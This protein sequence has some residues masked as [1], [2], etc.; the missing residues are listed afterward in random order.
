MPLHNKE[1]ASVQRRVQ[2]QSKRVTVWLATWET[3][4]Q[5]EGNSGVMSFFKYKG[6][7]AR[8]ATQSSAGMLR[9]NPDNTGRKYRF[10]R[11][12]DW[13]TDPA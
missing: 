9:D 10:P 12:C 8:Q 7:S 3:A 6:N 11:D 4:R 13:T 1:A 2:Q 5:S